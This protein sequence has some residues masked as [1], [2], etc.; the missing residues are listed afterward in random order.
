M[1]PTC[2]CGDL[3]DLVLERLERAGDVGLEHDRQLLELALA[4]LL[5]DLLEGDLARLAAGDLLG[6]DAGLALLRELAGAALV[7]DHLD[8]LA[9]L[10]DAVEAEHLDGHARRGLLDAV[11]LVVEQSLDL[12]PLGAGDD[13]VADAQRPALDEDAGDGAAA[14]VQLGLDHGAGGL[15]VRVRPELLEVG[16]EDDHLEQVVEAVLGLRRDVGVDGVPSPLLGV[17]VVAGE[18]G[19]DAV[20]VRALDVDLVDRHEDRHLGGAGVVDRLDRLR[21]H[22]V[23]GRDDDHRDVGDLGAAGAHGGEGLVARRVEEGDRLGV[24]VDLVGADVLGDPTGLARGD[25]GLADR[26]EQRG[27]SVVDVAHDRDHRRAVLEVG[28]VVDDL[29]DLD[30]L[31][32]RGDDLDLALE[33]LRDPLDLLVGER[34]GQGRHLAALHQGLD[35]LG[36]AEAEGLGHLANR[37]A[38][39]RRGSSEPLRAPSSVLSTG[40][41]RSGLRRRPPRRRGGRGGG[42]FL[43]MCS[44]RAACESMTTRRRFLLAGGCASAVSRGLDR[45]HR[46][47]VGG[48]RLGLRGGH[49]LRVAGGLRLRLRLGGRL[50][51]RLR[52]PPWPSAS[53]APSWRSRRRRRRLSP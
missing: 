43:A 39:R 35:H 32:G 37:R 24:V 1:T 18:L 52:G 10:A 49:R 13:G 44:R 38:R 46:L 21:H 3:R 25:L 29:L 34:L 42:W 8:V 5:E 30:L 40:S 9:G 33:L 41:S 11:A 50:R 26:I 45:A 16:D 17:Q 7:L 48:R 22:A 20:G 53:V 6:L 36:A 15:G 14:R 51:L 31:L 47:G 28:L 12:A 27:L 23:V 2:S 19:A 4:G